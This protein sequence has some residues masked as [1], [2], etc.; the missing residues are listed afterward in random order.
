VKTTCYAIILLLGFALCSA[1]AIKSQPLNNAVMQTN[2][3]E[4]FEE[5]LKQTGY[6]Y[7]KTGDHTWVITRSGNKGMIL[8][9]TGS[10]FVVVGIIVAEK[11]NMKPSADLYFK[12]LKMNDAEDYVKIGFDGDDDLF[13]RSEVHMQLADLEEIKG[14]LSRVESSADKIKQD[15]AAFLNTP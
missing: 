8:A 5:L 4:K 12:L 14:M 15:I 2:A 11:K 13:V 3:A 10:D 6:A 1:A 7:R 9:A